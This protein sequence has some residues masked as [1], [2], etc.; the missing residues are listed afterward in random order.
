MAGRALD[1]D[2]MDLTAG[3]TSENHILARIYDDALADSQVRSI[4]RRHVV[5]RYAKRTLRPA[6][7]P[8]TQ[9]ATVVAAAASI[10]TI[11]ANSMTDSL[12]LASPADDLSQP[13]PAIQLMIPGL[14]LSAASEAGT[15]SETTLI[16]LTAE[17]DLPWLVNDSGVC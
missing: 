3:N 16:L 2:N 1:D 14:T 17:L 4:D 9:V 15:A 12:S 10:V 6:R 5:A 7:S 13:E 11:S 8:T